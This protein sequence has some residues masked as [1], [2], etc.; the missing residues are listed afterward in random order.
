SAAPKR[1][2][3]MGHR[4]SSEGR[5]HEVN[6]PGRA[7][8]GQSQSW[9]LAIR[10]RFCG[11]IEMDIRVFAIRRLSE[12]VA[13]AVNVSRTIKKKGRTQLCGGASHGTRGIGNRQLVEQP[14]CEARLH[15]AS[16][17]GDNPQVGG[18]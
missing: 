15:L 18:V 13:I 2:V 16:T 17:V 5:S 10:D 11:A 8:R 12:S 1:A 14:C 6:P 9:R 7:P 3:Q 4:R